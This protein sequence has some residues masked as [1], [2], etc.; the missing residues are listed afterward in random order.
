MIDATEYETH[1]K[2]QKKFVNG[3]LPDVLLYE[4]E[5]VYARHKAL[6]KKQQFFFCEGKWRNTNSKSELG[7]LTFDKDEIRPTAYWMG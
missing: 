7:T 5:F 6:T 4:V 3:E 1:Y 2:L